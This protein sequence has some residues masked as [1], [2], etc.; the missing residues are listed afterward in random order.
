MKTS[1]F[2][3][4]DKLQE[5][6]IYL[7]VLTSRGTKPLSRIEYP[8]EEKTLAVLQ[9][10]DLII[11]PVKRLTKNGSQVTH[12][13]LGTDEGL[14]TEYMNIFDG[15]VI[16][17]ETSPVV[18]A[19]AYFFGYPSC[20]AQAYLSRNRSISRAANSLS[21]E[22]QALFFHTACPGCRVTPQFV[23]HYKSAL[24]TASVLYKKNIK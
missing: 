7:G 18:L 5:E 12:S 15:S 2:P 11:Q 9:E 19:E 23:S 1:T 20:C 21:P 24:R 10:L 22:D 6:A 13:I 8:I 16:D 14:I 17:G 4:N 3:T